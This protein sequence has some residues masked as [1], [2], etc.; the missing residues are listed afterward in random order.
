M[1]ERSHKIFATVF[2]DLENIHLI[3]DPGMIPYTMQHTYGYKSI[4]P[5]F[6]NRTYIYTNDWFDI[7]M[8]TI[9]HLRLLGRIGDIY[10][11]HKWIKRHAKEIDVLHLFFYSNRTL[12]D[13][14]TYQTQNKDGRVYVHCDSSS[15]KLLEYAKNNPIK[16]SINHFLV[17]IID[18]NKILWGI[19]DS[20][21]IE[22]LREKKP[23]QHLEYIPDGYFWPNENKQ[24]IQSKEPTILTVGRIGAKSKRTDLLLEGFR[25]ASSFIPNWKLRLIGNIDNRF[26][27]AIERFLRENSEIKNRIEMVGA[28]TDR[29]E[30][31]KEYDHAAIFCLTSDWESFGIAQIEAMSRGCHVVSSNL[32]SSRYLKKLTGAV[33][34]F[35]CGDAEDLKVSL[36]DAVRQSPGHNPQRLM[37]I[38]QHHFSWDNILKPV[39]E[40]IQNEIKNREKPNAGTDYNK[41]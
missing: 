13:I 8:P 17:K 18:S 11:C 25:R 22:R 35:N 39:A 6:D 1:K 3:K 32:S 14:I 31:Q 2:P 28:I 4:L 30:L 15:K 29:D 41:L 5:C 40:W 16:K 10:S 24:L 21:H 38:I 20:E 23:F 37:G 36:I 12:V 26:V 19:Q 33:T 9:H 34:L 7:E 27:E